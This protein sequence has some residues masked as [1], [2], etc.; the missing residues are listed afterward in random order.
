MMCEDDVWSSEF[1]PKGSNTNLVENQRNECTDIISRII[2]RCSGHVHDLRS[3][4][5]ITIFLSRTW[6]AFK[7]SKLSLFPQLDEAF[8]ILYIVKMFGVSVISKMLVQLISYCVARFCW[9]NSDDTMSHEFPRIREFH[10]LTC[11]EILNTDL[12]V[13]IFF[14]TRKFQKIRS[15]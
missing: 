2:P 3:F 1:L 9:K 15:I 10:V 12:L 14:D 6:L 4:P 11:W 8:G 5:F 13:D 7:I